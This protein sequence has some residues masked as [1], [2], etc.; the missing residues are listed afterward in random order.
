MKFDRKLFD[1]TITQNSKFL[2]YRFVIHLCEFM[3]EYE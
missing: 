3:Y 1:I 2:I